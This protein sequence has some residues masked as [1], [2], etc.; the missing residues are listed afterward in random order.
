MSRNSYL[1]TSQGALQRR[2]RMAVYVFLGVLGMVCAWILLQDIMVKNRIAALGTQF[3]DAERESTQL[4]QE[5]SSL[6]LRIEEQLSRQNLMTRLTQQRT[7]LRPI[8]PGTSIPILI[9][10]STTDPHR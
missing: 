8:Q 2:R 9:K 4:D 5:I 10:N 3:R 7:R 1:P 6:N